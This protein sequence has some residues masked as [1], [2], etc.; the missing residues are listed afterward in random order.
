MPCYTPPP[1]KD[2]LEAWARDAYRRGDYAGFMRNVTKE[3][4]GQWLCD[5]L[6]GR[7]PSEMAIKWLVLHR[8]NEKKR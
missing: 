7:P 4:L 8:D 1:T 6:G 2:E 5:A 3:M